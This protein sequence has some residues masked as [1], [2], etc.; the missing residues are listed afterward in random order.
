MPKFLSSLA[1]TL[2]LAMGFP[3]LPWAEES[4]FDPTSE[5]VIDA[6]SYLNGEM[7]A[8]SF[9]KE[10]AP[11][12]ADVWIAEGGTAHFTTPEGEVTYDYEDINGLAVAEGDI[13][14]GP[15]EEFKDSGN[16]QIRSRGLITP[17]QMGRDWPN[18]V[19][20]YIIASNNR[21]LVL[22]AIEGIPQENQPA[23]CATHHPKTITSVSSTNY[24]SSPPCPSL[25]DGRGP[26]GQTQF[27]QPWNRQAPFGKEDEG[28]Y[29][30]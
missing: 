22:Q 23:V 9:P 19:V 3:S 2:L 14:L 8:E 30:S 29:C 6:Q 1:L 28:Y 16:D 27:H 17:R 24:S 11:R 15:I 10:G 4:V 18:G 26:R 25:G 7:V 21:S 20:P 12:N 13:I 5:T